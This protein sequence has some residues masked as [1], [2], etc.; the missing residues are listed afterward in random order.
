MNTCP[1]CGIEKKELKLGKYQCDNCM[2]K[3]EVD[4]DLNMTIIKTRL[5]YR[6]KA[7]LNSLIIILF[8]LISLIYV[9][10]NQEFIVPLRFWAIVIIVFPFLISFRDVF[11]FGLAPKN[12]ISFVLLFEAFKGNLKKYR[13]SQRYYAIT[14]LI[15]EILGIFTLIITLFI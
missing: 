6:F 15:F 1:I 13:L 9:F 5:K 14:I 7:F 11:S 10:N 2:S 8:Y 3:F 4:K 12:S